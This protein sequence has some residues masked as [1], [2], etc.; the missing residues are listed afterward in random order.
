MERTILVCVR[1][2]QLIDWLRQ[3]TLCAVVVLGEGLRALQVARAFKNGGCG[4]VIVL[5]QNP[6]AFTS[7][8]ELQGL[9][10]HSTEVL[11]V[12]F[13]R[14][15][16]SDD[17][18]KRALIVSVG[19]PWI[20]KK[21]ILDLFQGRALN[22]HPGSLPDN[23]GASA[24]SWAIM[25]QEVAP[26]VTL[27]VME[28][29]IDT[30]EL[31]LEEELRSGGAQSTVS[32]VSELADQASERLFSRFF[33]L[34]RDPDQELPGAHASVFPR[35]FP[36]LSAERNGWLDWNWHGGDIVAFIQAFSDPYDGASTFFQGHRV[37]IF[38]ARFVE[39]DVALH[40][41]TRGLVVGISKDVL[42]LAVLGGELQLNKHEVVGQSV[43]KI[44]EGDRLH[45]PQSFLDDAKAFRR[46]NL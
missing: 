44:R 41:F 27:H 33:D 35:Y 7:R 40:P 15:L 8:D 39:G 26:R 6:N 37:K 16:I 24:T 38:G 14:T 11:S 5:A 45:T 13:V 10:Y 29:G 18:L 32:Q 19:A 42:R 43:N 30:G 23:K 21:E 28:V 22:L 3:N 36:P 31:I 9:D 12:S 25:N 2:R 17:C 4:R 20:V 34:M 46:K 1:A